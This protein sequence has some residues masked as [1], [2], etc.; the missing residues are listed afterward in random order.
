MREDCLWEGEPVGGACDTHPCFSAAA[1]ECGEA[2]FAAC[3][4]AMDCTWVGPEVGGECVL[5]ICAPCEVQEQ[6]VCN[7]SPFCDYDEGEMACIEL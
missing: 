5:D 4:E 6:E 1:I 2:V 7:A 3:V